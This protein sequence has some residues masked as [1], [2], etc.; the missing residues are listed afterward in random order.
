MAVLVTLGLGD[1]HLSLG[2][3][4][5]ESVAA[6]DRLHSIYSNVERAVSPVLET[7]R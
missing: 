7:D 2:I 6:D 5:E 4:S 1:S 3:Y